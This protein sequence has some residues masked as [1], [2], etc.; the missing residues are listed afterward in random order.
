MKKLNVRIGTPIANQA[1]ADRTRL[2]AVG[3][4]NVRPTMK[5]LTSCAKE[6]SSPIVHERYAPLTYPQKFAASSTEPVSLPAAYSQDRS[7]V[8]SLVGVVPASAC[9][10]KRT[11]E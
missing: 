4:Q 9:D 7:S 3:A 6:K 1:G 2:S 5:K 11:S 8:S 10:P